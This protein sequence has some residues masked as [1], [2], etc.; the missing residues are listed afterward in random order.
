MGLLRRPFIPELFIIT[1][2]ALLFV[3][4]LGGLHLFDW[5]EIN[6]AESAREM[7]LTGDY[8]TVRINFEPF[9]EKPPLFF[10]F[11]V[12]S[13][14][15]FGIGEFA[16][17]FPNAICGMISLLVLYRTGR[18]I[19]DEAFGLLWVLVY[20]GSLLPFFYFKSGII[21][22]WF[23]LFIFLG[24][25][26]FIFFLESEKSARRWGM[27]ALSAVFVGLA[28]LTKGPVAILLFGLT[29]LVYW[30][31]KKFRL[32][33]NAMEIIV[34]ILV[35]SLV[36]GLWFLLQILHGNYDII[37]DFI[38][39][40]I[41]LFRTQ[42]AGHGGFFGYHVVVLLLGVF[43][44]SVFAIK[45]FRISYYDDPFQKR[46][47]LWMII[48]FL[49]VLVIFSVVRTKIVHYSSL[50]Y[51][52]LTFLGADVVYR[53]IR[54]KIRYYRWIHYIYA[55]VAV[56]YGLFSIAAP[57]ILMNKHAVIQKGWITD[58][59]ARGQLQTGVVWSGSEMAIGIIF[60]IGIV[61]TLVLVARKRK[62]GYYLIFINTTVYVL[63]NIVI[64]TP[65]IEEYIQGALIEFCKERQ[66]ED[67]YIETL[68]M[69]SYAHYF[70]TDKQIPENPEAEDKDWLL[71][72]KI[73]KPVYFILR[74]RSVPKFREKYP[75]LYL[76]REK[77][78]FVFLKRDSVLNGPRL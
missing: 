28:V 20:I 49:V 14:R 13:M 37:S 3:P 45:G 53:I 39:Y 77:N 75:D 22:P 1:I 73:D 50:C 44:A 41:R 30:I 52:P 21:D 15:I 51:F 6:F 16:A 74:N 57:F 42:D 72:G 68:G 56:I 55:F 76:Y 64:L 59:F 18:R 61:F 63:L 2:S 33:I 24:L 40:Q 10:W 25:L 4:F 71:T 62:A 43:P 47:K 19:Y 8:L 58:E 54:G 23:N 5:D 78:G 12:I 17:R 34:F 7:I 35:L 46:F 36:G 70:Y 67:C 69:K 27:L 11:Q 9:W 32:K 31:L 66:S 60:I 65:K 48:L 29:V 38:T 26:Q